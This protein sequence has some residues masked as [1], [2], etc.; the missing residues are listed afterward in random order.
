M[1]QTTTPSLLQT[2]WPRWVSRQFLALPIV[3]TLLPVTF[4][5]SL[6]SEAVVM[7]QVRRW[8]RVWRRLLTR[9]DKRTSIGLSE[10]VGTAQQVHCSQ[11]RLVRSGLEFH[12]CTINKSAYMKKSGNLFNDSQISMWRHIKEICTQ[13]QD[14]SFFYYLFNLSE[15]FSTSSHSMTKYNPEY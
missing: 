11:R 14:E 7:R 8:K 10:V 12:A 15:W 13:C 5:Y 9:S 4:A 3:K 1:H 2:I 6:S